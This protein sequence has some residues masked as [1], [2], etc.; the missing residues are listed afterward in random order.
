M[1]VSTASSITT[2]RRYDALGRVMS[3]TQRTDNQDYDFSY[4]YK[5]A[6]TLTSVTYPSARAV[7][8][9][10]D[11]ASRPVSATGT[12]GGSKVFTQTYGYDGANRLLSASETGPGTGWTQT[13]GRG[14]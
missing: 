5:R 8:Y 11:E 9:A 6:G 13:Y 14:G 3:S 7:S 1:R 12:N 10:V 2:L 4:A